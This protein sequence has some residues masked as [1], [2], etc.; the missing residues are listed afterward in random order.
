MAPL[1]VCAILPWP[2]HKGLET[3]RTLGDVHQDSRAALILA[4]AAAIDLSETFKPRLYGH[5]RW[6]PIFADAA[7]TIA[8]HRN[9]EIVWQ[10]TQV[11][12]VAMVRVH[13]MA[14]A[15]KIIGRE[16]W[17]AVEGPELRMAYPLSGTV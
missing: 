9:I 7:E 3:L 17:S 4:T 13:E 14:S 5:G 8:T 16:G 12:E 10:Y 6:A 15:R 1:A 2:C 11:S